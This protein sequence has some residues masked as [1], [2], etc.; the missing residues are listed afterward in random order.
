MGNLQIKDLPDELHGELRRRARVEGVTI[1]EYVLD[2][3]RRDQ[4]RPTR[5]E[6]LQ[7]VRQLVPVDLAEPASEFLR[8][9]RDERDHELERRTGT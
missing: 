3:L 1:R 4:E 6:W 8:H 2:L 5:S 9:D 7:R